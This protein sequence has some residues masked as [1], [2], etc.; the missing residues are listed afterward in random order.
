M[1]YKKFLSKL[2]KSREEY[3]FLKRVDRFKKDKEIY[4]N[5][6]KNILNET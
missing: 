2:F 5:K 4:E 3:K 1:D 6:Y